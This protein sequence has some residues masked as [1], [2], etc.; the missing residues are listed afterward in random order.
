VTSPACARAREAAAEL[1]LG[2]LTGDERATTLAHLATCDACR[3]AVDELAT[4]ADAL[5]LAG[6]E[7]EPPPGFESRVLARIGADAPP[8]R[9][10]RSR[11]VVAAIVVA[12]AA[13]VAALAGLVGDRRSPEPVRTLRLAAPGAAGGEVYT[14]AGDPPWLFMTVRGVADGI[15]RCRLVIG[16]EHRDIGTL[17]VRAGTGAWGRVLDLDPDRI[18]R[19]ELVDATGRVVAS[20]SGR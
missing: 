19:V 10:R 6:P 17:E 8:R 1:A 2:I 11:A 9:H 3:A 5:L 15:Y 20:G 16:G 4:T 14:Y 13:A 12:A 18:T 7:I